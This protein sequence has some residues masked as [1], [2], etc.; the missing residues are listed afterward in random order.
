MK[1]KFI[2]KAVLLYIQLLLVSH[3]VSAQ[4]SALL[5]HRIY[6]TTVTT[7]VNNNI[8]RG[9]LAALSDS[10][11]YLSPTQTKFSAYNTGQ[12]SYSKFD[13]SNL[14]EMKLR[15]KGTTGRSLLTGAVI[16]SVIGVAA[17][18]I[19]G[20]DPPC[21]QTEPDFFGIGY[22]LYILCEAS[23]LSAS[24]K[25]LAGGIGGAVSGGLV[26][27]I[28]GAVLHKTFIIGGNKERFAAM[29]TRLLR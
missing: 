22:G 21:K 23:R 24:E 2:T 7:G 15:R 14:G 19:S 4:D 12:V 17:G 1:P 20:D 26:G 10:S 27:A 25:A 16:G 28:I 8:T 29:K 3:F 6:K 11:I 9:Y 5:K 13:V 18:F